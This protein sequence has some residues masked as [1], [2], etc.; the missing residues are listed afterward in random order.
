[1]TV[2]QVIQHYG[3]PTVARQALGF[4][5]QTFRNWGAAKRIPIKSQGYIEYKSGGKLKADKA[6]R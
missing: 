6:K 1:M 4:T 3:S 5:L 2:D